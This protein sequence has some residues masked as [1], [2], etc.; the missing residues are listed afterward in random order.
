[1]W[2]RIKNAWLVLKGDAYVIPYAKVYQNLLYE[3]E[4]AKEIKMSDMQN[5]LDF[6]S[7]MKAAMKKPQPYGNGWMDA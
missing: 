3:M 2:N 1:M 7:K 4:A 5:P 6:S